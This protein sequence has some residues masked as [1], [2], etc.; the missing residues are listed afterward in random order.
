M[1]FHGQCF[2]ESFP[3]R[4]PL[5]IGVPKETAAGERRVALVPETAARLA[6]SG[7]EVHIEKG[8]GVRASFPDAAYAE[9]GALL[10]SDRAELFAKTDLVVQVGPSTPEDARSCEKPGGILVSLVYPGRHLESVRAMNAAGIAV[11]AMDLMPRISRAQ[12]M[13]VLSSQATAA[14]YRAALL[15][16]ELSPRFLPMLTTAFG[17]LRPAKVLVCG[18]GVAGLMAIA[19]FRRLGAMVEA[20]DVRSA[21]AEQVQSLGAKFLA[22]P[23]EASGSGGYA[24]ELT[25]AER[26]KQQAL[27]ASAVAAADAVVTTANVPGKK[28][29]LIVTRDMVARMRPAAVVVDAAAESGGNC[30]LTKPGQRVEENGVV[31]VGPVNL[32]SELAHHASYMYSKNI[33]AFLK[34]L[35]GPDGRVVPAEKDEILAATLLCREGSLRHEPTRQLLEAR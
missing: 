13:D 10:A 7:L 26:H 12:S 35:I 21:A 16:A 31:I 19:T 3:V 17:T 5:R 22:L 1:A 29:P 18:A 32:P 30:E 2:I 28:A 9:A 24:R 33:E 11:Y 6:K 25:D 15:A 23:L 20:Y 27:L 34:I 4:M 14:G 8:A